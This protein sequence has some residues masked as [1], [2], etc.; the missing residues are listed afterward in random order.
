[1]A[2]RWERAR[3]PP[4]AGRAPAPS[5]P[6][7][8]GAGRGTRAAPGSPAR[9]ARACAGQRARRPGRPAGAMPPALAYL[10]LLDVP[11]RRHRALGLTVRS[12]RRVLDLDRVE[13]EGNALGAVGVAGA[14]V[15]Y[16]RDDRVLH[17]D[18][19]VVDGVLA[20][21]AS[22]QEHFFQRLGV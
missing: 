12:L 3:G 22:G 16:G 10:V 13:G 18:L 21:L 7:H 15:V 8:T 11:L 5:L 4:G 6:E 9:C 1:G 14:A 17:L 20:A 2:A 19:D